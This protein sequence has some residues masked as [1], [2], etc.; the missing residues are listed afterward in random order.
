MQE[1][2]GENS[3]A[4]AKAFSAGAAEVTFAQA[5]REAEAQGGYSGTWVVGFHE[6]AVAYKQKIK[7]DAR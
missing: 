7:E 5:A 6:K 3:T 1:L 4:L 2:Q